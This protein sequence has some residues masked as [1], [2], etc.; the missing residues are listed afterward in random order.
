MAR[1]SRKPCTYFEYLQHAIDRHRNNNPLYN[2]LVRYAQS[3]GYTLPEHDFVRTVDGYKLRLHRLK[4]RNMEKFKGV[5]Y[6]QHGLMCSSADYLVP[7]GLAYTLAN[8]GYDVW[9]GNFRGNL[10]SYTHKE[11]E[12]KDTEFWNFSWDEHGTVDLYCMLQHIL[13]KTG[14]EQITFVGHS[15]GTTAFFVMLNKYPEMNQKINYSVLLAPVT[16]VPN[17]HGLPR[18]TIYPISWAVWALNLVR[19]D[20]FFRYKKIF[21]NAGIMSTI[22]WQAGFSSIGFDRLFSILGT[23]PAGTST[24]NLSHYIENF[25]G[26]HFKSR[27]GKTT[28]NLRKI[29]CPTKIWWTKTDWAAGEKDTSLILTAL[30]SE[31]KEAKE[32]TLK[33]FGHLDFLWDTRNRDDLYV[34]IAEDID[35]YYPHT[36]PVYSLES[37]NSGSFQPTLKPPNLEGNGIRRTSQLTRR[38]VTQNTSYFAAAEARVLARL[39]RLHQ[40]RIRDQRNL[41]RCLPILNPGTVNYNLL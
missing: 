34:K 35:R 24:H 32:V 13:D 1:S 5:I 36:K 20:G 22:M 11:L 37:L 33:H 7:G 25:Y 27:D 28:Y 30:G 41:F 18:N 21:A 31:V 6:L 2:T 10:Y 14:T 19:Y 12:Q 39:E 17:M 15:M 29:T 3:E 8:R 23:S 40:Q 9:M 16:N 26:G 4:R 38:R